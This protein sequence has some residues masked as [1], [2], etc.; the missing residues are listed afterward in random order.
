MQYYSTLN[1]LPRCLKSFSRYFSID[2]NLKEVPR[3]RISEGRI[4]Y[5]LMLAH[6]H[7][8]MGFGMSI[9]RGGDVEDHLDIFDQTLAELEPMGICAKCLGGG[10]I[11]M[12]KAKKKITIYG[13]SRTFGEAD[14]SRTRSILQSSTNYKDFKIVVG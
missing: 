10:L 7:G 12:D 8:H 13:K 2:R 4:R 11:N 5:L 14:H 3:V 9:I 6:N 1:R